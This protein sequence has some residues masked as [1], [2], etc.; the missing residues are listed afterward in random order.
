MSGSPDDKVHLI[1]YPTPVYHRVIPLHDTRKCVCKGVQLKSSL[2]TPLNPDTNNSWVV[3]GTRC[4]GPHGE[5][6]TRPY[7]HSRIIP[8]RHSQLAQHEP[9]LKFIKGCGWSDYIN[10]WT[11]PSRWSSSMY[12]ASKWGQKDLRCILSACSGS[13]IKRGWTAL[14]GE[15]GIEVTNCS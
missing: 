14:A 5:R 8:T 2:S 7:P 11:L 6:V 9:K 10:R 3:Q 12:R 13:P 1:R 4:Q 15:P